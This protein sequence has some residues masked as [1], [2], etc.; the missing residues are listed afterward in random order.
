MVLIV[1]PVIGLCLCVG[2]SSKK[3]DKQVQGVM[4]HLI[5]QSTRNTLPYIS[6]RKIVI[7]VLS[8]FSFGETDGIS[9]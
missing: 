8:F 3:N 9:A 4:S 6:G 1:C 7:K 5:N 2:N